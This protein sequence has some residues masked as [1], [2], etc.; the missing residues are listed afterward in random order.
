MWAPDQ[1]IF[2]MAL[3]D[4]GEVE[5][6]KEIAQR[7]RQ[8]IAK[9]GFYENMSAVDGKGL[10]CSNHTRTAAGYIIMRNLLKDI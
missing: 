5:L 4:M 8:A 6:A 7:Y 1:V 10:R 9:S 2:S 3:V